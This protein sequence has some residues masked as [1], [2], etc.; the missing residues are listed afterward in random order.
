MD[1]YLEEAKEIAEVDNYHSNKLFW[2]LFFSIILVMILIVCVIIF[3]GHK[4]ISSDKII[5]GVAVEV[6]ETEAVKFEL[7][8][9]EHGL[10]IDMVGADF[11]GV[12]ISSEPVNLTLKIGEAKEV[13]LNG[14]NI[15]ELKVKLVKIESG[16]KQT[17]TVSI[18]K[19]RAQ[20]CREEWKCQ[21]WSKCSFGKQMRSCTDMNFCQ[22]YFDRP[23]LKRACTETDNEQEG[24]SL[25]NLSNITKNN[26]NQNQTQLEDIQSNSSES[27]LTINQSICPSNTHKCIE[28]EGYYCKTGTFSDSARTCCTGECLKIYS[29]LQFCSIH[30]YYFFEN[31]ETHICTDRT[32]ILYNGT[33][34][35]CCKGIVSRT[36]EVLNPDELPPQFSFVCNKNIDSFIYASQSCSTQANILCNFSGDLLDMGV[37][38]NSSTYY[39]I[40]GL[41]EVGNCTIYTRTENLNAYYTPKLV[42]QLLAEGL[43]QEQIYNQQAEANLQLNYLIGKYSICYYPILD[44]VPIVKGWKEGYFSGS[45][46]DREKYHCYGTIYG[47]STNYYP[48]LTTTN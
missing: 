11:I 25:R 14:D 22:T 39:E 1:D 13:D 37:V 10:K 42:Q 29:N 15:T 17:A 7:N 31:N 8:E 6:G 16:K 41:N 18:I 33:N 35:S 26:S 43:T 36:V 3:S 21:S 27:N 28:K 44:W 45:S 4:T 2:F 24:T 20:M 32:N 34:I 40:R 38:Q 30:K 48:T 5:E 9:E 12:T 23:E 47:D 46:E 19:M